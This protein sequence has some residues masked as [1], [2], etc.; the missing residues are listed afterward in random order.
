[1]KRPTLI[2]LKT[3]AWLLC[4]IPLGSLAWGAATG[5]LGADPAHTLAFATGLAALRILIVTL[6]ITPVRK[7][8]PRLAWLVRFRR[9]TG[10]FAFFY[11]T[12][13]LAVWV[14]LYSG[15]DF[16]AMA[17]DV[18]KRR[19]I[20]AGMAAFLMLA[21]LA[22]TSTQGAIRKLGGKRWR[23][24]HRLVYL[25][26]FAALAHFWWQVKPGVQ[27]QVPITIVFWV[28]MLA[29]PVLWLVE[30]ARKRMQAKAKQRAA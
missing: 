17:Q 5:G 9:L 6:A 21:P 26:A 25:A 13:H 30:G 28:L 12:L 2:A 10:L 20:M 7:L 3:L 29:R 11:A 16:N 23:L 14:A 15:F 8:I 18:V 24:L 4:L 1:M 19:F 27:T 22:A